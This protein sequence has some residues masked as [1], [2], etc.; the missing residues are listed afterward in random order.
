MA[1]CMILQVGLP[2]HFWAKAINTAP[3]IRSVK[4]FRTFGCKAYALNKTPTKKKFE[5]RS[6]ECI[7]LGYSHESKAYRL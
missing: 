5:P 7:F 2:L 1:R 6:N 3:Y 4:H